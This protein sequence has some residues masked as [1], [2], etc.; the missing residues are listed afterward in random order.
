LKLGFLLIN[1]RQ[2]LRNVL[3]NAMHPGYVGEM[4]HKLKLRLTDRAAA[5]EA[6]ASSQWCAK[7]AEEAA[8]WAKA[9]DPALWQ[10]AEAFGAE[11]ALHSRT[12]LERIGMPLAGGGFYTLIYFIV[13]LIRPDHALETGVA[14]GYS[15]RAILTA[16]ARNGKGRLWSSDFPLFRLE[17]P[18]QFIGILVEPDLKKNWRLLVRGDRHNLPELLAEMPRVD[19]F[20]F[21]SDKSRSGREFEFAEIEPK[22]TADSVVMFDDVQDNLHFKDMVERTGRPYRLFAFGGKWIGVVMPENAAVLGSRQ[23]S[24]IGNGPVPPVI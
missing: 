17:N 13:R 24:V 21:D 6:R 5:A 19:F 11:H 16:M 12:V 3:R 22:L 2:T 10:E 1:S 18:E 7:V 20:H 4:L 23:T 15:S 8:P 9:I 14:A